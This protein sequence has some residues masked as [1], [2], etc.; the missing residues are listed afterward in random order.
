MFFRKT[1]Q[2]GQS[3]IEI[4]IVIGLTAVV[5][6]ALLTGLFAARGGKAQQNNRV[7]AV[8]LLKETEEVVR[9]IREKGWNHVE[10][11]GTYHPVITSNA[12]ALANGADLVNGFTRT[13]EIS[14]VY[15]DSN[16]VIVTSGGTKDLSTKKVDIT[17]NWGL[18]YLSSI[19][20]SMYL[21]RYLDNASVLR[22]TQ[23]EF[24]TGIK[25]NVATFNV[26][27]GEITLALNKAKWCS[28]EFSTST[29]DLP[30]GPPVAVAATSSASVTTPNDVFVATAPTATTSV[31]LA[32]VNV[33]ANTDPPE[34]SL[35]GKFT[36]DAGQYSSSELVPSGIGIDNDFITNDV[37]YYR[38]A[39]GNLYAL[40]ATTKPD[41]EIIAVQIKDGSGNAFQDPTNKIYKYHT[42]FNTKI[43]ANNSSGT[44]NQDHSPY[45]HGASSI[46]VLGD[47]GYAVSGGYLYVF[48]L[49]NIDSKSPS[50]GLDMVGCRIELDGY[51]CNPTT[52]RIRK[53]GSGA[54]GTSWG[55]E[56]AGQNGCYDGGAVSKY[57]SNS[58]Y[59][60]KA[61]SNTYVYVAVGAGTDP[62]LNIVNVTT[63]PTGSTSPTITSNSCGRISGGNNNWRR[64]GQFDF[65]SRSGTQETSNSV[66][67]KSDGTRA[68]V[69]S[70]G[71]VDGN[72]DGIADSHQF[73]VINTTNKSSPAFLSGSP[74]TGPTSGYYSGDSTNIQLFPRRSLTVLN[75][76]RA[77]VVGQDG[78]PNDATE[79]KGYQVLN[80]D[81]EATPAY[82]GGLNF[83]AGFNDLTSVTEADFDN[84]VYMVANTQEKQLKIIQGGPDAIYVEAGV[85]TSE[86]YDFGSLVV[87]NRFTATVSTPSGTDIKYQVAAADPVGG[88]CTNATY[89]YLGPDGTADTYYP[90]TGGPIYLNDDG[91]GYENPARCFR[92][93]AYLSTTNYNATPEI[94]D[95]VINYTQ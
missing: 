63:V 39:S 36:L 64:I 95:V 82:C 27:G 80:I 16:G 93:K 14:D 51:D 91:S 83:A 62:E 38:S 81:T 11:N 58:I 55:S 54:T 73:Y 40:V 85:Y 1:N 23:A 44:P 69:S 25:Q 28:P 46:A 6:P 87:M 12:W 48:N 43:N 31:K 61:G 60:V 53:Y 86:I 4:L 29:I 94:R 30:D 67:A 21:T 20:S 92:Y 10:S 74:S 78:F 9:S 89:S 8:A 26:S 35:V 22:T 42:F 52:S 56:N 72:N 57:A 18:P 2:K 65:N 19:N 32:Y 71:G 5:L 79:P 3:L 33:T 59:P 49:S 17:I 75:G 68:Y 84:F 76:Q 50:N 37:K 13:I 41:K 70:N 66:F 90:A 15:R 77:V 47:R 34:S 45:G 24:D 7:E 88:S